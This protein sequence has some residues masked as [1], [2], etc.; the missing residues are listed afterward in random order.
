MY[1][2]KTKPCKAH[3][4]LETMLAQELFNYQFGF[5]CFSD[6][7]LLHKEKWEPLVLETQDEHFVYTHHAINKYKNQTNCCAV[8]SMVDHKRFETEWKNAV[9][10][11]TKSNGDT[12]RFRSY[13][14]I[15]HLS[16]AYKYLPVSET[17]WDFVDFNEYCTARD[18]NMV[19]F[20]LGDVLNIEHS[21]YVESLQLSNFRKFTQLATFAIYWSPVPQ[22]KFL[23]N[24]HKLA[25]ASTGDF[26]A[27]SRKI[28][29]CE[30]RL[31]T[32]RGDPKFD[33]SC[34]ICQGKCYVR[35]F[36]L[37]GVQGIKT[38]MFTRPGMF[39]EQ[40]A[41]GFKSV[42]VCVACLNMYGKKIL[43]FCHSLI[44]T[45]TKHTFVDYLESIDPLKRAIIQTLMRVD[46]EMASL[47]FMN[48]DGQ[49]YTF[50]RDGQFLFGV[51][52]PSAKY[53]YLE[54]S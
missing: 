26:E 44:G 39:T 32:F 16:L 17:I 27:I 29:S 34:I 48:L 30:Y 21:Q 40:E 41:M 50:V 13:T 46:P 33:D 2:V 47:E 43:T 45:P 3:K 28:N 24:A 1:I 35:G 19:V 22:L 37:H 31:Q 6:G 8:P 53:V 23:M 12:V 7:K 54:K 25:H 20:D 36:V 52:D 51:A 11:A 18:G 14:Q 42:M 15:D 4:V 49:R 9:D 38:S 5:K 10:L